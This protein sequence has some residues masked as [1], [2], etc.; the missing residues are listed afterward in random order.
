M[1]KRYLEPEEVKAYNYTFNGLKFVTD[2]AK[3]SIRNYWR[4]QRWNT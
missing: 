3:E 1:I 4:K 2:T